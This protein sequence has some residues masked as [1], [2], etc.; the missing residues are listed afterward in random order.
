[1]FETRLALSVREAAQATGYSREAVQRAILDKKLVAFRP[2]GKGDYRIL[3][4]DLR[5]W[6]RGTGQTRV[7]RP[8]PHRAARTA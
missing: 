4:E 7:D 3:V 8:A 1:M 6:L 2:G 5:E